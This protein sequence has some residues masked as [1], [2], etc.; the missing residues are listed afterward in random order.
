MESSIF[1][2]QYQDDLLLQHLRSFFG[3]IDPEAIALFQQHL[4]WIEIRGGDALMSQGDPGDALYLLVSGR[5]RA[6]VRNDDGSQRMLRE[7]PRGEIVGEMSLYTN[8]PRSASVIAIRDSVLVRLAKENFNKL[9]ASSS[10]ISIA[11][12]R[13]I[14]K[15]LQNDASRAPVNCPVTI[16]VFPITEGIDQK[17]FGLRLAAQLARIGRVCVV[18]A[19]SVERDL[20]AIDL[21]PDQ[22]KPARSRR[23]ISMLLDEI[24]ARHDFVLLVSDDAPG[25]WTDCCMRHSDEL[26]LLADAKAAPVLHSIESD[27]LLR[28]QPRA[29]AVEILVLLHSVDT[30]SPRNTRLWLERRPVADHIHIRPELDRD[31]ARLARI[32]SRTA[33]GLVLAGGGARGFAH[34]GIY[35]ALRERGVEIDFVGGTSIG[36]VMGVLFASDRPYEDIEKDV[37]KVFTLNPTGDFNWFPVLSLIKGQ[38]LRGIMSRAVQDFLGFDADIEDLWKNFYCVATNYSRASEKVIRHGNIVKSLSASISIPGALPPVIHNGELLCDGGTFN[39]CPVD[40]MSRT[41]GVGKIIGI[42]L[43]HSKGR[44]I[45]HENVPGS[46][47]ILIDRFRPRHRRRYQL[48]SLAAYLMKVTVLYSMSR[49]EQHKKL[50]D[51]YFNPPLPRVGMLE[52]KKFNQI[53]GQGYAYGQEIFAGMSDTELRQVGASN[54][55][56]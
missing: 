28:R 35:R 9:L 56:D 44:L 8:E 10:Q 3:E 16:G 55:Q 43:N 51:L 39:N 15:R 30:R 24:E 5:L 1:R 47:A 34:I 2:P 12:T 21:A 48:P 25:E 26:L 54:Q 42:D 20:G 33:V 52:W 31:M 22:S 32:E 27:C 37:R 23:H 49:Q 4:E 38:R 53:V 41:R 6:Y 46:L 40:V 29:E 11:L 17:Q 45:K 50:T 7:I 14:I 19:A 13:Q 18:D 36:S